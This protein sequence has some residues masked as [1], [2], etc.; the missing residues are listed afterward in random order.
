M[1]SRITIPVNIDGHKLLAHKRELKVPHWLKSAD[2]L[3]IHT[4][5]TGGY[6]IVMHGDYVVYARLHGYADV[7]DYE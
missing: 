4:H 1:A 5:N 3:N 6:E 2:E 7:E